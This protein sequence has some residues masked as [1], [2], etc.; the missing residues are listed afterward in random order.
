IFDTV[1]NT[2]FKILDVA[3]LTAFHPADI[4]FP[5]PEITDDITDLI[6]EKIELTTDAIAD[7]TVE[8]IELTRLRPPLTTAPIKLI[9]P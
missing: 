1:L 4:I 5:T 6:P 8:K 2:A 9:A 3:E 7:K